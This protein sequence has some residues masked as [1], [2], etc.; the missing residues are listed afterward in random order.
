M[1][2]IGLAGSKKSGK[3]TAASIIAEEC[4]KIHL[5]CNILA[6]ADSL[7]QEVAKAAGVDIK[8]LEEHKDNFRLILQ[9]WGT[10]FRRNLNGKDY[11]IKQ[12]LNTAL[13]FPDNSI[14]VCPDVRFKNELNI[15]N[16]LN[17]KVWRVVRPS[18]SFEELDNHPSERDLDGCSLST[19]LNNKGLPE[20]RELV[21]KE[22]N[23][24]MFP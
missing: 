3:S 22:F 21:K 23:T 18:D 2:I 6:F 20:F 5:R 12:W 1:L 14:V 16:E 4:A 9:G 13:K 19:L 8:F 24:W 17:A 10:D 7:K 15:L 11:W